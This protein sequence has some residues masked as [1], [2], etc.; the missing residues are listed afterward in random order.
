MKG[1]PCA[2]TAWAICGA[3]STSIRASRKRPSY[4]VASLVKSSFT[5]MLVGARD[6]HNDRTTRW[7]SE[8]SARVATSFG[9]A[10][11]TA[12]LLLPADDSDP[13]RPDRSMAPGRENCSEVMQ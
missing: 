5:W 2:P 1:T 12:K 10:T 9:S 6:D 13:L 8:A 3:A 7:L 11:S 4:A